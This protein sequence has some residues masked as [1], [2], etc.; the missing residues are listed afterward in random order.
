[1]AYDEFLI[2]CAASKPDT[3]RKEVASQKK[4]VTTV[5][6]LQIAAAKKKGEFFGLQTPKAK[7]M[8][9]PD[10]WEVQPGPAHAGVVSIT[11]QK[12]KTGK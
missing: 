9:F 1:M 7:R 10:I 6:H 4:L 2:T 3:K 5:C 11:A 12:K 8:V